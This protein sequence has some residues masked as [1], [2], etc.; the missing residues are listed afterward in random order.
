[1]IVIF[2][3]IIVLAY[4]GRF[5]LFITQ[6]SDLVLMRIR[7]HSSHINLEESESSMTQKSLLKYRKSSL[8]AIR[9]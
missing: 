9:L 5:I 7:Q 1:M 6:W 4:E 8:Q 2:I 3:R